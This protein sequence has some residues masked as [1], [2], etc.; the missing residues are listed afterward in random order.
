MYDNEH[1]HTHTENVAMNV[2]H[3]IYT[4]YIIIYKLSLNY[5][6]RN[7]VGERTDVFSL[8]HCEFIPFL[9]A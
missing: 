1:T 8:Q 2:M 7:V 4:P 9:A 3:F 5:I 6:C